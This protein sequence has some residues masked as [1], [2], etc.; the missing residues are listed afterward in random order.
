MTIQT[1]NLSGTNSDDVIETQMLNALE[2]FHYSYRFREHLFALVFEEKISFSK[3]M[4]DLRVLQSSHIQLILFCRKSQ[5][6]K[7]DILFWNQRG[8]TFQLF[9]ITE[10]LTSDEL[11][12]II[13]NSLKNHQI[14]ILLLE[15]KENSGYNSALDFDSQSLEIAN[16]FNANKVFFVSSLKGLEVDNR[17][18]SYP[19]PSEVKTFL[20]SSKN[21]NIGKERL[22]FIY[23]KNHSLDLDLVLLE[24][25]R[26][27]LFQEIFTHRGNGTLF[28]S[29]YTNE[30]YKG[31]LSDVMELSLLIKSHVLS[32]S[33]LPIS[34]EEISQQ[35]QN[36]FVYKVNSSIVATALLKD[37]D[38]CAE[39]ATFC[40]LPR[41]QGRGR[42]RSVAKKMIQAAKEMGK[43]YVFSLSVEEKMW[44]FFLGLGFVEIDRDTLSSK[45]KKKYNFCRP[46]KAFKLPLS[47]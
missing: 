23:E 10:E 39:L 47:R 24:G 14:P 1:H 18:Y 33:I 45:W 16:E 22:Q 42:A 27:S 21:I 28:T 11:K 31:E 17:F 40:T 35:I 8:C 36:F 41:Y 34:E 2:L 19:T 32:G 12:S 44:P 37:Y 7:E 25:T 29:E 26:G 15:G 46:S 3:M 6:S 30:I 5:L 13:W 43:K 20:A 4:I 38:D 9:S